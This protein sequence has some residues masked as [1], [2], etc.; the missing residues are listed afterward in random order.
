[1]L[2]IGNGWPIVLKLVTSEAEGGRTTTALAA[3]N[4]ETM[5]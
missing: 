5:S 4:I 1:M 3:H 2:L